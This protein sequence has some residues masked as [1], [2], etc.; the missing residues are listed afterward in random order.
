MEIFKNQRSFAES[1][2]A[3]WYDLRAAWERYK[4][5]VDQPEFTLGNA[6]NDGHSVQRGKSIVARL[7]AQVE[8]PN[9][10]AQ[11]Y[12]FQDASFTSIISLYF[13]VVNQSLMNWKLI[14]QKNLHPTTLKIF[15]LGGRYFK[16]SWLY[17]IAH[18][19]FLIGNLS[20]YR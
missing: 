10:A 13:K 14:Y 8:D 11:R 7:L 2:P 20:F 1:L 15:C 19:S 4:P 6:A 12:F 9:I 18:F 3:I 5:V 17:P 16:Y